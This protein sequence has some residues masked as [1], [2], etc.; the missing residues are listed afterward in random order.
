[1]GVYRRSSRA[2]G[3][4]QWLIDDSARKSSRWAVSETLGRPTR[5]ALFSSTVPR[6]TLPRTSRPMPLATAERPTNRSNSGAS[7]AAA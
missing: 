7:S 6:G 4:Q 1:M 5:S 3:T 2:F